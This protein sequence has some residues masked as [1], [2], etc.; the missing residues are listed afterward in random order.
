[1][2]VRLW[3]FTSTDGLFNTKRLARIIDDEEPR[4][5]ESGLSGVTIVKPATLILKNVNQTYNG[6]YQ[7]S[8]AA[9]SGGDSYVV[10]F[11]ASKF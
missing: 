1:M 4:I 6:I 2:F 11:I 8:L 10:V 3:R 9:Y 5:Y 7:F